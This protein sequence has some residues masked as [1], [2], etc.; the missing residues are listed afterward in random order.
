MD[1]MLFNQVITR[2]RVRETRLLDKAKLERMIDAP[3][4]EESLKVLQE[5]DYAPYLSAL[6]RPEEYEYILKE[7]LKEV[8]NTLYKMVPVKEVVDFMS[9]KYDYHNLKVLLKGK[10]VEKDFSLMLAPVGSI[11]I[12]TLK[13]IIDTE[14]YQELTPIMKE[15]IVEASE[16]YD[17]SKDP[18]NVDIILDKHLF[19]EMLNLAE[20][21]EEDYLKNYLVSLIDLTNIKILLRIKSQDKSRDF[22]NKALISGG[23]L[24]KDRLFNLFSDATDNIPNRLS[25][26]DYSSIIKGGI[27]S[28]ISSGSLS[29][30]EKN[31]DNFVM[32]YM[33]KAKVI[34]FGIE[35]II[36]YIYAKE[37]EIKLIRIILLGKLNK[38]PAE[39]IRE[40][41]RDNYV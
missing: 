12:S 32:D 14:N 24:D 15:A 4:A 6:K 40:R 23:K 29:L 30:L 35:P 17:V 3:T 20:K 39:I 25:Y 18:Q 2:L 34:P 7:E 10:F 31:I 28:Y 9:L 11:D 33:K 36:A 8:Y 13:M 5:S 22:L 38:V 21:L 41:L 37:N 1:K 27:D 19:Q 26:S 16:D